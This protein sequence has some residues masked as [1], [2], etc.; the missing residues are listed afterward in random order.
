MNLSVAALV[1]ACV[2]VT[3]GKHA[4]SKAKGLSKKAHHHKSKFSQNKWWIES[5]LNNPLV[6]GEAVVQLKIALKEVHSLDEIR[7]ITEELKNPETKQS[8]LKKADKPI[9]S[10][11]SSVVA[12]IKKDYLLWPKTD[13]TLSIGNRTISV[14]PRVEL[15]GSDLV[16]KD[17]IWGTF[18]AK[19]RKII[20]LAD[21]TDESDTV[22]LRRLRQD[23]AKL[24]D[25]IGSEIQKLKQSRRHR[26]RITGLQELLT[27]VAGKMYKFLILVAAL[28][29][30][31]ASAPHHHDHDHEIDETK[32]TIG[33]RVVLDPESPDTLL[34]LKRALEFEHSD[35]KVSKIIEA[36]SQDVK[37][38][39]YVIKF[40]STEGKLCTAKYASEPWVADHPEHT[41]VKCE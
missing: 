41:T 19:N 7:K 38:T 37:G 18:A 10:I 8:E 22:N 1:L 29:A 40:E 21:P 30:C 2:L 4:V 14:D 33:E 28:V 20:N 6:Y 3:E 26:R 9:E 11:T 25:Q 5:D 17:Y 32:S 39:V 15:D 34:R 31:A 36:F 24:K 12:A 16:T 27:T 23:L 13:K 35:V